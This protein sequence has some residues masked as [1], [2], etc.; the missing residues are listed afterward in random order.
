[1]HL[2]KQGV[3]LHKPHHANI[4]LSQLLTDFAANLNAER[5]SVRD[6]IDSLGHR[7]FGFTLLIFALPNSLPILGI[8]GVST[9]TG[10]PLLLIALQM[11]LRHHRVYMPHWIAKQSLATDSFRNIIERVTPWI[12]RV[13]KLLKPRL[14]FLTHKAAEPWLGA[15]CVSLAALLILPIPLGNLLPGLSILLI[16]LG[17][18]EKD[19]LFV[20]A[21]L[22]LAVTSWI[23]LRGLIWVFV[24][25]VISV[26]TRFF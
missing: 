17:L 19:G 11:S 5:V 23:Y 7:S 12:K 10:L 3:G 4:S 24:E 9:I 1:M 16:A 6:I 25:V 26:F 20:L 8:P 21:G 13:E 14:D 2:P 22:I 15:V 18:I